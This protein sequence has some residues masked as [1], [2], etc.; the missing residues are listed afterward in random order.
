MDAWL[1]WLLSE[2]APGF[3]GG[4][5]DSV[6]SDGPAET[7]CCLMNDGFCGALGSRKQS[8]VD[9][10]PRTLTPVLA[11]GEASPEMLW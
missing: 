5:Y 9:W 8:G 6:E 7:T 4:E 1:A 3:G 11:S 2:K 10:T